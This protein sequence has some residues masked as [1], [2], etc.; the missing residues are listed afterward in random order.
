L[1]LFGKRKV[2]EAEAVFAFKR[3]VMSRVEESWPELKVHLAGPL[4]RAQPERLDNETSMVEFAFAAIALQAQLLNAK[5]PSD[6]VQ[7][8]E[9]LFLSPSGDSELAKRANEVVCFYDRAWKQ[10]L[11][12]GESPVMAVAD[13][14]HERL[15]C[16]TTVTFGDVTY[17]GASGVY[18]LSALLMRFGYNDWWNVLL[19]K[20]RLVPDK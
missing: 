8:V 7:R 20:F 1:Q 17:A 12:S 2:T 6:Q 11:R 3:I 16:A 10:A 14:L 4:I 5:M 15:A 19:S 18:G 13:H 9:Q